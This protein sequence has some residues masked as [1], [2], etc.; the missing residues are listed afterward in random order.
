MERLSEALRLHR[1]QSELEEA[2]RRP[3][4]I[5]VTEERKLHQ[6]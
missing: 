4:G 2:V 3:G 5:C 6:L 1:R